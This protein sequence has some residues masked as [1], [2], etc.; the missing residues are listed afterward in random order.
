MTIIAFKTYI[1]FY[2]SAAWHTCTDV[3]QDPPPIWEYGLPGPGPMDLVANTGLLSFALDNSRGNSAGTPGYYSPGHASAASWFVDGLPIR[4]RCERQDDYTIAT[5]FVGF[6]VEARPAAGAYGAQ[7]VE[8]G[9]R[10]WMDY[11]YLQ[12]VG[13]Q[14]IQTGAG[15]G[16]DNVLTTALSSFAVQ[17]TATSFDVGKESFNAIFDGDDPDGAMAGLFQKYARNE[18]GGHI[19]LTGDGTLHFDNRHARPQTSADAFTLDATS[20]TPPQDMEI[21]WSRESLLNR[22]EVTIYPSQVD[23]GASTILWQL[24]EP[25]PLSPGQALTV[26][27]AYIDPDTGERCAGSGIVTPLVSGTH[28]KFGS[29]ADGTSNDLIGSLTYPVTVGGSSAEV[30]LTNTGSSQGYVNLLKLLGNGIYRYEPLT[31][32]V[33]DATSVAARGAR[34]LPI[35][36]E[37]QSGAAMAAIMADYMVANFKDPRAEILLLRMLANYS[38]DYATAALTVEPNTRFA[39]KEGLTGIDGSYFVTRLRFMQEGSLLWVEIV[40]ASAG[41]GLNYFIWDEADHGW[42]EGVLAF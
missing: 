39:L 11:A 40:P 33:E 9:A 14:A 30:V 6:L 25:L 17:P 27:C 34:V 29:V 7:V 2:Y 36:L 3:L 22:V 42:D 26:S 35:A 15:L 8:V 32:V 41:A 21:T 12:T 4:V 19:Y 37:Q 24:R 10:D 38:D 31:V 16:V 1:Q 13:I 18:G 5:R 23:S 20:D 28:I